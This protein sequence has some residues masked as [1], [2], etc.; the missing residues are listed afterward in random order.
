MSDT[1]QLICRDA[2]F[3]VRREDT[4]V[5]RV[6]L[7]EQF[8]GFVERAGTVY[9][10]LAGHRYDRAVEAGQALSLASAA[11]LLKASVPDKHLVFS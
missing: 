10:A 6:F 4:G 8:I 2:T 11:S 9:V 1:V 7:S 3:T 5:Y